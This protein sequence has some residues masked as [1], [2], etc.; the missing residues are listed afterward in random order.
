VVNATHCP[1]LTD[2]GIEKIEANK[3]HLPPSSSLLAVQENKDLHHLSGQ[4]VP[5]L[6][7]LHRKNVLPYIQSKT[8]YN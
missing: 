4:P 6:H 5:V 1:L 3:K 7:Y 2:Y 8:G